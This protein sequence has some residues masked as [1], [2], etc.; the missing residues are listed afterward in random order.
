[1]KRLLFVFSVMIMATSCFDV[2]TNSYTGQLIANFEYSDIKFGADSVVVENTVG[3]G[4]YFDVLGFR[5]TLSPDN[6]WFDGGF[7][8]SC[9]DMTTDKEALAAM[10]DKHTYR[11]NVIPPL[12]SNTY[13]VH[14]TN[15][16]E[17]LMPEHD[18]EFIAKEDG[19]CSMVG[20]YVTNTVEV[21]EAVS[22]LFEKGDKLELKATGWFDS[23]PTN[24]ATFTLAD[25]SSQKDSIVSRWTAFD[26]SK[27]GT[28]EYVDFE[29]VAPEGKDIPP[30][31]CIDNVMATIRLEY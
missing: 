8:I 5:H 29:L 2:Q 16:D 31:F 27:L 15:P 1:M 17:N 23:K 25:F 14:Y 28:V 22:K 4:I 13:L 20:C 7:I 26:L 3:A 19:S 9:L 21:A 11:A 18:V 10:S 6:I 30:Y 24:V 12:R